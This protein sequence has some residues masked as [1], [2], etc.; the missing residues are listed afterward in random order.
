M[1]SDYS[2]VMKLRNERKATFAE[3]MKILENTYRPREIKQY[4]DNGHVV[5]VFEPRWGI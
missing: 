4:E 1:I 2:T 5:R 3:Q